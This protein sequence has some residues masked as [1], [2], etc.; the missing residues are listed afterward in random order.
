ML[1]IAHAGKGTDPRTS[2]ALDLLEK[3]RRPDGRWNAQ[4]QWWHA[5]DSKTT[6]VRRQI[7]VL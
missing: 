5:A 6:P 4:A 3:K 2:D 1:V 7:E